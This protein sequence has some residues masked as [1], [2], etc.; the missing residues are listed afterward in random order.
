MQT[1]VL[2]NNEL[3]KYFYF[4][5]LAFTQTLKIEKA[6]KDLES[7]EK[8]LSKN[9]KGKEG[10]DF[11]RNIINSKK[12]ETKRQEIIKNSKLLFGRNFYKKKG[13]EIFANIII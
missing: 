10:V 11:L 13:V 12:E 5:G 2:I 3:P 9:E 6:E 4:R 7:L 8:L 1:L